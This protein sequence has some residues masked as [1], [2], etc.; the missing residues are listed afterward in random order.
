MDDLQEK[1]ILTNFGNVLKS[2]TEKRDVLITAFLNLLS[3][4][5][6]KIKRFVLNKRC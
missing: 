5:Q 4:M 2:L 1:I 6:F 3:S